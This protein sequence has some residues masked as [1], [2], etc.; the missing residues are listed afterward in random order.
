MAGR[1]KTRAR[2][3]AACIE[4]GVPPPVDGEPI[5]DIMR[6]AKAVADKK[7]AA[8]LRSMKRERDKVKMERDRKRKAV[9]I[10]PVD[11]REY[12]EELDGDKK[13]T[14]TATTTKAKTAKAKTTKTTK[15]KTAKTATTTK[16]KTTK[17]AKKT[18]AKTSK[19]PKKTAVLITTDEIKQILKDILMSPNEPGSAR[20]SAATKLLEIDGTAPEYQKAILEV[21]LTSYVPNQYELDQKRN[22]E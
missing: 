4:A 14:K 7:V 8:R 10:E 9:G 20:I 11:H 22:R 18:K 13:T 1:P 6:Q 15:A 16:A 12:L 17:T 2:I 3:V 21:K 19:A 5:T